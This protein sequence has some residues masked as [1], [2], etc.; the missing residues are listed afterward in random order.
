MINE[1]IFPYVKLSLERSTIWKRAWQY[2]LLTPVL[3]H[4]EGVDICIAEDFTNK[5]FAVLRS[6]SKKDCEKMIDKERLR[7]KDS[8]EFDFFTRYSG[9]TITTRSN[10]YFITEL[11]N[12]GSLSNYINTKMHPEVI[13]EMASFLASSIISLRKAERIHGSLNPG[14]ILI[15]MSEQNNY[16]YRLCGWH[17]ENSK[18]NKV[19]EN[20]K[21][22]EVLNV[23]Y[24]TVAS[25]IWSIG[26]ILYQM[27]TGKLPE[28]LSKPNIDLP[29]TPYE[30]V[31]VIRG[32]LELNPAERISPESILA[33]PFIFDEMFIETDIV[34]YLNIILKEYEVL[35]VKR[36]MTITPYEF[37]ELF[38]QTTDYT[39]SFCKN[40]KGI[41]HLIRTVD[42]S[43]VNIEFVVRELKLLAQFKSI[44]FYLAVKDCFVCDHYLHIIMEWNNLITLDKFLE[45]DSKKEPDKRLNQ[46]DISTIA[47]EVACALREVHTKGI[48]YKNL[49]TK[50]IAMDTNPIT[51]LITNVKLFNFWSGKNVKEKNGSPELMHTYKGEVWN[52]GVLLH[53]LEF[54]KSLS[55]DQNNKSTMKLYELIEKCMNKDPELRPEFE[56]VTLHE[57][58][59]YIPSIVK[60][61]I[62]PYISDEIIKYDK[63]MQKY[64]CKIEGSNKNFELVILAEQNVSVTEEKKIM[65]MSRIPQFPYI[66]ALYEYFWYNKHLHLIYDY[67]EG[68]SL[69]AYIAM[70]H[71]KLD[72]KDIIKLAYESAKALRHLH[73]KNIIYRNLH[74]AFITITSDSSIR[75]TDFDLAKFLFS[76]EVTLTQIVDKTTAI[77]FAPEVF[78]AGATYKADIWSYGLLL[79]QLLFGFHPINYKV[80][81]K[82]KNNYWDIFGK[83]VF[84]YPNKE[85]NKT[86]MD[87]MKKCLAIEPT[88]RPTADKILSRSIFLSC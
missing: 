43:T 32:C 33:S 30:L 54:P 5:L 22:P 47:W 26:I 49:S 73:S 37:I 50:Y 48:I 24:G 34:D 41:K 16:T 21:A 85:C 17:P 52:Y 65:L 64:K 8:Y 74:P 2:N 70:N 58:F 63:P 6:Y 11:C 78:N 45:K 19:D 67:I 31:K 35:K 71:S 53:K 18:E 44:A 68:M 86:L 87:I 29:D 3:S 81:G 42:I 57:Y 55:K 27:V 40:H 28:D 25:E 88:K 59:D 77:Y 12:C 20:Y 7:A 39:L 60:S 36:R 15:H 79:Y 75:L 80:D 46:L 38:E 83:G 4:K 84:N 1:S 82:P 76:E 62:F 69:E 14:H 61:S 51:G 13:K 9:N 23:Q 56:K 66:K 72:T 10:E